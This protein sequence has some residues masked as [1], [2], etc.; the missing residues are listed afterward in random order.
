MPTR[1]R[2]GV[3][4]VK[5]LEANG[6][7]TVFG[8]PGVHT[9]EI[10]DAL[11]DSSITHILA[12]HEQGA[13]FMADGYA[14]ATGK[15]GV[16]VIIT[17]PGITNVSTPVGEAYTDSVP[18]MVLSSNVERAWAGK[19]LGHLHDLADQLGVMAAV[20]KW[21]ER[22][23]D[24][25]AIPQLINTAFQKM[26]F[27][28]PRPTHVEIPLDVLAEFAEVEISPAA[29]LGAP[30]P[31]HETIE[32]ALDAITAASKIV[33]NC[34]GGAMR[35]GTAQHLAS[36]AEQLGAPVITSAMGKGAISDRHPMT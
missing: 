31:E 27:G 36:L 19:E 21:N 3:A 8:I 9:L 29:S 16:A 22:A 1:M 10:Y 7:D 15:P 24:V 35:E 13:G 33:I 28:R 14:R 25:P 30:V 11:V 17:G 2:G 4:A 34:G 12:R 18:V 23:L 20:T 32:R 26:T 5:S 6:V